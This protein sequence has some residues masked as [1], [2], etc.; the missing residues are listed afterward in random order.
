MFTKNLED[1]MAHLSA[2]V[3]GLSLELRLLRETLGTK[4][5]V[6]KKTT[7]ARKKP[8]HMKKCETC[9]K[10]CKGNIGLGIHK[11]KAH[12]KIR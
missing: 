9:G 11:K 5:P 6:N 1:E 10:A 12:G 8:L 7:V 3:K 2:T 4:V